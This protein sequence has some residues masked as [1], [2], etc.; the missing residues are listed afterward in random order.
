LRPSCTT[1][2]L[3]SQAPALIWRCTAVPSP[4]TTQTKRPAWFCATAVCGTTIACCVPETTFTFTYCPGSSC[5]LGLATSARICT[6]PVAASTVEPEKLI[7]PAS[8]NGVPSASSSLT[9]L[10]LMLPDLRRA[11]SASD[12]AKRIHSG[13]ARVSVVR[14]AVSLLGETRLPIDCMARPVMP[15]IGAS[16][17]V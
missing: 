15:S 4:L 7:L 9:S 14:I 2:S 12:S 17:A 3:P 1:Q 10:T 16:T 13:S 5:S 11:N 8:W 6:V